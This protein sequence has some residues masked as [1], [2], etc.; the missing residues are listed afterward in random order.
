MQRS[1]RFFSPSFDCADCA[2]GGRS[3]ISRRLFYLR[4]M[5]SQPCSS[6][7]PAFRSLGP[8]RGWGRCFRSFVLRCV[9]L[10]G[11]GGGPAI[12]VVSRGE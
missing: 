10:A 4:A 9:V 8:H 3:V 11:G 12:A 1:R 2:L 5:L 7:R 6:S